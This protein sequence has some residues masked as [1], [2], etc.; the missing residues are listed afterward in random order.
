MGM[1]KDNNTG[2]STLTDTIWKIAQLAVKQGGLGLENLQHVRYAAV[3][4]SAFMTKAD[5]GSERF[6]CEPLQPDE[7][8]SIVRDFH[9]AHAV[10]LKADPSL[11]WARLVEMSKH[12][13]SALQHDLTVILQKQDLDQMI[14]REPGPYSLPIPHHNWLNS[15]QSKEAGLWLT[16][17]K[18]HGFKL[19]SEEFQVLLLYRCFGVQPSLLPN[20]KC[21]CGSGE[22]QV[23]TRGHH[24]ITGCTREGV[25]QATHDSVNTL[26]HRILRV[27]G[28]H[29]RKEVCPFKA[30][31]PNT[32]MRLDTVVTE[33]QLG[34][35]LKM[36]LDVTV[37]NPVNS[38]TRKH[39]VPQDTA[40][41]AAHALKIKT[42][43]EHAT[44]AN[45]FLQPVVFESTGRLHPDTI[46]LFKKIAG[47]D[48]NDASHTD[49]IYYQYWM[50]MMSVTLQKGFARAFIKGRQ[51]LMNN[52]YKAPR[53]L[54]IEAANVYN[55]L[56]VMNNV[57]NEE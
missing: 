52:N 6:M 35:N 21:K 17:Y 37:T 1:D 40:G 3:I 31:L 50:R 29:A 47:V 19:T 48:C 49:K 38:H 32:K 18:T 23:D 30:V 24:L 20:F 16:V 36:L 14:A 15:L 33:G 43:G 2:T 4:A 12:T 51:R 46:K 10:L 5:I 9:Q 27:Y 56:L 42:Y 44:A 53:V 57:L 41:N 39:R 28:I 26:L 22:G 55:D 45:C 25:R 7:K 54:S 11:T 8:Y 34:C 13:S